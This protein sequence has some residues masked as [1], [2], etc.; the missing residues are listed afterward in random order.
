MSIKG[1]IQMNMKSTFAASTLSILAACGGG[2]DGF[3]SFQ[4]LSV[5]PNGDGIARAI[6]NT[7]AQALIYS[8]E[9]TTVVA[10]ANAANS[11][12]VANVSAS[13][14][15]IVSQ[16][17]T[18]RLRRGTVFV[19][20]F[21][22][23][24]RAVEDIRTSNAAIV[25]FEAPQGSNDTA[26]VTGSQYSSAPVGSYTFSGTQV[27][28]VRHG[29]APGSIGTFT[30]SANFAQQTFQYSGN[31]GGVSVRG[32]GVLDTSHGRF[33]TSNL[34]VT[35][36]TTT[37]GGTMHGLLHGNGATSTSG[38]FHAAGSSPAYTG[39]FVGSR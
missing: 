15:P 4:A 12:S 1:E 30:L 3:A 9:I 14:F 6:S 31:S 27:T 39:A 35:S 24:V 7:G 36:G 18:Y 16:S 19:D 28:T 10:S 21:T 17:G 8:P 11:S 26:I 13:D 5:L 29:L 2:G 38:V 25:F 20:G 32:S 23:N 37:Y 33:A 34:S 22:V